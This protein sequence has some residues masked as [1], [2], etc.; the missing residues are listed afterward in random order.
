MVAFRN[1]AGESLVWWGAAAVLAVAGPWPGWSPSPV[2]PGLVL[3]L[4][5]LVARPRKLGWAAVGVVALGLVFLRP[6][7][8]ARTLDLGSMSQALE[9]RCRSMLD[10]ARL[11]A[12]HPRVRQAFAAAGEVLEPSSLFHALGEAV[13]GVAGRTVYLV[14]DRGRVV[15]WA[16][17]QRQVP[18]GVQLLGERRWRIEWWV[19]SAALVLR[20]PVLAEGKL[21]GG[22]LVVDRAAVGGRSIWGM[23]QLGFRLRIAANAR[24]GWQRVDLP[25]Y[26]GVSLALTGDRVGWRPPRPVRYVPWWLLAVVALWQWPAAAVAVAA[27]GYASV[28]AAGQPVWAAAPFLLVGAGGA[29]SFLREARPWL[30]NLGV[31]LALALFPAMASLPA[32]FSP[33]SWLPETALVPGW[34]VVGIVALGCVIWSAGEGSLGG[35]LEG[36]LLVGFVVAVAALAAQL[37]SVPPLLIRSERRQS[38][39]TPSGLPLA[40]NEVLP[41]P[42]A[43]CHMDDLAPALAE[44]WRAAEWSLPTS[45]RVERGDGVVVSRWG[46][47]APAGSSVAELASWN[48]GELPSGRNLVARLIVASGPWHWLADWKPYEPVGVSGRS[49]VWFASLGRGGRVAASLHHSIAGIST[50]SAG[51]I[52][53]AGSGWAWVEAGDRKLPARVTRH[54][55]WLVAAVY[56]APPASVWILRFLLA[57]LWGVAGTVMAA[58]PQLGRG[59]TRTFGGRLRRLVAG[60][61]ILPLLLLTVVLHVRLRAEVVRIGRIIAVDMLDAARWTA[62][63]LE[64]GYGV[65]DDL[66]SWLA[67][68][69]GAEV[70]IF[71]GATIVGVSRPD[72]LAEWRLPGLP[73]RR[74]FVNLLLGRDDPAV[75]SS[76]ERVVASGAVSIDGR[77]YLLE[78]FVR[79]PGRARGQP[80]VLDWLLTGALLAALGAL[81]VTMR[82]ERRLGDSLASVVEL[83][84]RVQKGA[85]IGEV[86]VPQETDLAQVVESVRRMS[87]E[88][89]ERERRLRRQEELLRITLS[90][91]TQAVIVLEEAGEVRFVNPAGAALLEEHGGLAVEVAAGEEADAPGD[92]PTV[93]TVQPFPGRDVTWR[94]GTAKVPLPGGR[95]GRVVVVDDISEVVRAD[96]LQQLTEMAR[97]VAHEVKNPLTPIRL[98]V[99]ELD[100]NARRPVGDLAALVRE[101]CGEISE[102]VEKLRETASSFSNLVALESWEPELVDAAE[103]VTHLPV[104]SV[105]ERRGITLERRVPPEGTCRVVGDRDWIL[106]ALSNLVQNSLNVLQGRRGTIVIEVTCTAQT[107]SLEVRDTGGGVEEELLP[108]LFRPH[109]STTGAGSGL[110]LALVRQVVERC[111]GSVQASNT[112]EGLAVRLEFPRASATM[113]P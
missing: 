79:D 28:L 24:P 77:P 110:G 96:R 102:Q 38:S 18:P 26:P 8:G 45:I 42:L 108:D 12:E 112:G 71:D 95:I 92:G 4:V 103:L 106:R 76:R 89:Q 43:G 17:E 54:G 60:S 25:Q 50:R 101:A 21:I 36:R 23:G 41:A 39:S 47:L 98:W 83:A 90:T 100:E 97:I 34:A 44:R 93:K 7:P 68:E 16:G 59:L 33:S 66:A 82:V 11:A 2:V 84:D 13:D 75:D 30:R 73:N 113:K 111:H 1:P 78:L 48:L 105:L 99:Q 51:R 107:V 20:E 27:V 91:L 15:A 46:D 19:R 40:L 22:I 80:G 49:Q 53:H 62:Q 74:G 6:L 52:W 70:T 109:F 32:R 57:I 81:V 67:A 56:N 5:V 58:R 64:G 55:D 14:D 37:V 61:V 72:L 35:G 88:V 29:G 104:P 3:L 69:V 65:G 86:P 87:L 85:V 31:A 63:H 94:V 9:Q 10:G